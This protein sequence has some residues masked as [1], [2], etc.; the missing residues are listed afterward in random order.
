MGECVEPSDV[1]SHWIQNLDPN[2]QICEYGGWSGV[3][4][5]VRASWVFVGVGHGGGKGGWMCLKMGFQHRAAQKDEGRVDEGQ[6]GCTDAC[7]AFAAIH[8]SSFSPRSLTT[9]CFITTLVGS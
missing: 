7:V 6:G 1:V 8:F 5:C 2:L 4:R 3:H 9:V